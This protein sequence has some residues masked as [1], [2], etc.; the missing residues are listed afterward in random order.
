[1]RRNGFNKK[2]I[3]NVLIRQVLA[4]I[5]V[6]VA[7]DMSEHSKKRLIKSSL[8]RLHE[9]INIAMRIYNWKSANSITR[10]LGNWDLM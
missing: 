7:V 4:F 5:V 6:C 10:F 2:K 8:R 9:D 1:M 3:A